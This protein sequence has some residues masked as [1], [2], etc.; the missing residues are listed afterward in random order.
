M[1]LT[2]LVGS[3]SITRP[4]WSA[5]RGK[6]RLIRS[7]I[8]SHEALFLGHADIRR[9][10]EAKRDRQALLQYDENKAIRDAETFRSLRQEL[11]VNDYLPPLSGRFDIE[12]GQWAITE[13]KMK[14]W[15]KKSNHKKRCIWIRGIPGSGGL[16]YI[17]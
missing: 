8:E 3:L 6:I 14:Q 1:L 9:I 5:A 15:L 16:N 12:R 13:E 17:D 7:S 10:S 11:K 4:L 2:Y